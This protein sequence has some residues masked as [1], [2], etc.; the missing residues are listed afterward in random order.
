MV[1]EAALGVFGS[2]WLSGTLCKRELLQASL[3]QVN[4]TLIWWRAERGACGK[5]GAWLF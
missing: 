3:M 1:P 2:Q 4:L 5:N